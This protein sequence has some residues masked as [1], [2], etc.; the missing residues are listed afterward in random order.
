MDCNAKTSDLFSVTVKTFFRCRPPWRLFWL[1]FI[2]GAAVAAGLIVSSIYTTYNEE[3]FVLD[4]ELEAG[5]WADV[6]YPTLTICANQ[7]TP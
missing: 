1:L 2:S 6:Q 5:E 7:V 3:P 4:V